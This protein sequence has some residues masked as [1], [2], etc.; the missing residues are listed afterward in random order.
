MRNFFNVLNKTIPV[1][2]NFV[3]D[4]IW[5]SLCFS[6]LGREVSNHSETESQ[7]L[8]WA[9]PTLGMIFVLK[10]QSAINRRIFL[11]KAGEQKSAISLISAS[12]SIPL[13]NQACN[14][15][16][17]FYQSRGWGS[18]SAGYLAA[19]FCGLVEGPAQE[20][21]TALFSVLFIDQER[22][23]WQE[24]PKIYL[25]N[26]LAKMGFSITLG[27]IPGAV[28]QLLAQAFQDNEVNLA[29]SVIV[30]ALG[31]AVSNTGYVFLQ[32]RMID[33]INAPKEEKS[34]EPEDE[35][36]IIMDTP[37]MIWNETPSYSINRLDSKESSKLSRCNF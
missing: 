12:A 36:I 4:I 23:L 8:Q 25:K 31:V 5:A 13:W 32:G 1:S 16:K 9:F 2:Y 37:Y 7:V 35:E 26:F 24:N 14:F 18:T 22:N 20:L 17:K 21:V 6:Y 27:V 28:W 34:A 15:G 33:I 3:R 19:P 11:T 29:I 10:M 30:L